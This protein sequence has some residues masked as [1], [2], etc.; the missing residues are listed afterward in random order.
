[1]RPIVVVS[2]GL[3]NDVSTWTIEPA[4]VAKELWEEPLIVAYS[5]DLH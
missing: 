4:N 3:K 1:M 2:D 5:K